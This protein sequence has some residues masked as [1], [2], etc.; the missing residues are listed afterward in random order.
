MAGQRL[1]Q[2]YADE[3]TAMIRRGELPAG[4]RLPSV[5][6]ASR[7]RRISPATVFEAYYLLQ[8]RGL[9]ESRPRSGF[10]VAQALAPST[11]RAPT[12]Q[13]RSRD[14]AVSDLVFEVLS[15]TRG[16][17]LAPLGSAFPGAELFPLQQLARALSTS[18]RRLEPARI[19]EDLPPGNERLRRQIALRYAL[20][21]T[22]VA[23]DEILITNG[24]M[25]ALTLSLQAVTRPGDTVAVESPTFYAALQALERLRLK[26]VEIPCHP[27][28]GLDLP[29]LRDALDRHQIAA[30]WFMPNFQNPT[31]SSLPEERRAGLVE[32]LS[33]R[34]VPLIEDDVYAELYYGARPP[35]PAKAFDNRG[36]V[37]HCS[38]FSKCL[39]PGYRIGWVAGGRYTQAI[40]RAKIMTT[41]SSAVPSQQA[42]A[43]Y[44]A[45][46]G[47]ERHLRKL[48]R[49][50]ARQRDLALRLAMRHFPA[51]TR[52]SA[53]AGGYF[54]WVEFPEGVDTLRIHREALER[55]INIA[56]GQI[57][58]GTPRFGN[59]LRLNYGHPRDARFEPA[60]RAIGEL[61]AAAVSSPT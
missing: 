58:S 3:L 7:R 46:G 8:A 21:G 61:A 19:V 26:A 20:S 34:E 11:S 37:M 17:G 45:Q 1:Y 59:C 32:L 41:L 27:R 48:R 5:R 10:F 56:P 12:R 44:L 2:R 16:S 43:S 39:A 52:L 25:E 47:Y 51:G 31:G 22:R 38:S 14:V 29:T 33:A 15:A 23:A 55:G 28:D 18:M 53:P 49:T 9:V 30:C 4:A 35:K 36:L 50:L 24:A 40:E 54:L 42:L 60:V 6:E 13:P 57:F